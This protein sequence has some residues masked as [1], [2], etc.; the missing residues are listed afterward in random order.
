MANQVRFLGMA[1]AGLGLTVSNARWGTLLAALFTG[2]FG[3][4]VGSRN[5]Q[6][7]MALLYIVSGVGAAHLGGVPFALF[8][9]MSGVQ[10]HVVL[11]YFPETKGVRRDDMTLTLAR[12]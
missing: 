10:F 9:I 2:P 4:H 7:A 5:G 8:A 12:I 6:K 3:D 1:A 11:R